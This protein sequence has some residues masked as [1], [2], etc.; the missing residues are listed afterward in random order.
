[1]TTEVLDMLNTFTVALLGGKVVTLAVCPTFRNTLFWL[2]LRD[3]KLPSWLANRT[4]GSTSETPKIPINIAFF[5]MSLAYGKIASFASN[6][7]P[8]AD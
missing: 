7:P 6:E 8:I 5:I 1:M 4:F 2:T 3:E